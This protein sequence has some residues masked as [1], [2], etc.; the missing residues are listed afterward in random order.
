MKVNNDTDRQWTNLDQ[1]PHLSLWFRWAKQLGKETVTIGDLI[2]R[3][4]DRWMNRWTD[5]EAKYENKYIPS[6]ADCLEARKGHKCS[7]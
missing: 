2:D 4:N 1:K 6:Y 3:Q 7:T 5:M